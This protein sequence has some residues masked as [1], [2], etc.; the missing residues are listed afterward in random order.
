MNCSY[1][2]SEDA[3]EVAAGESA[4]GITQPVAKLKANAF[5]LYDCFNV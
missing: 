5:G 4:M 1:S 3:D 2:G